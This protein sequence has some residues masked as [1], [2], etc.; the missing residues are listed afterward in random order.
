MN[1]FKLLHP[2][3]RAILEELGYKKPTSIQEKAIPILC[4]RDTNALIVAPTG[5]GKTEAAL[6]PVLSKY[7]ELKDKKHYEGIVILWITP[8]R[9]LNRDFFRR[10]LPILA[11]RLGLS[12]SVRHGDTPSHV[13]RMQA[14]K[15]P[16]LLVITPETLQAILWGTKLRKALRN[17]KWVIIDEVQ[18]ILD[19]KRGVQLTIGLE[20]LRILSP[21]YHIIA[22]SATLANPIDAMKFITGG[23]KGIIIKDERRK[24]FDILIDIAPLILEK[25]VFKVDFQKLASKLASYVRQEKGKVLIFTNTRDL[26]ELIGLLLKKKLGEESVGVHHSSLSKEVRERIERNFAMGKLKCVVATASLELGIDIGEVDLVVQIGSP[27]RV[28][29]AIQRIG[30]SGHW[31]ERVSRGIIIALTPDDLLESVSIVD[32]ITKGKL[33]QIKPLRKCYD[34]LIHQIVGITRDIYLDRG[35]WPS[36]WEVYSIVKNAEPY[37]EL[38][39]KEFQEV[40]KFAEERCRLIRIENDRIRLRK[41]AIQ[42]YFGQLSTIPTEVRF[43]VY[44]VIERKNIGEID[45]KYAFSIDVGHTFLLAGKAREV[46]EI[47]PSEKKVIV[48]PIA[49]S[50]VPPK[51]V[52]E[53]FPVSYLVASNIKYVEKEN[54]LKMTKEAE[55]LFDNLISN[56]IDGIAWDIDKDSGSIVLV[57]RFGN[58]VNRTI[59]AALGAVCR[60]IG[61]IPLISVDVDA[62]RIY[63]RLW[64][65]TPQYVSEVKI[66]LKMLEDIAN[67]YEKFKEIVKR[68]LVEFFQADLAWYLIHVLRRLGILSPTETIDYSYATKLLEMYYGTLVFEEVFNEY[69][70]KNLDLEIAQE[71]LLN[72]ISDKLMHVPQRVRELL[73]PI[74]ISDVIL[75]EQ[76]KIILD[77]R[78]VKLVC[79]SCGW[80]TDKTVREA[81]QVIKSFSCPKCGSM[82]ITITKKHDE[83]LPLIIQKSRKVK[84]TP[85]EKEKFLLAL[86][87]AHTAKAMPEIIYAIATHGVSLEHALSIVTSE[88]RTSF[89]S[90]LRKREAMFFKTRLFWM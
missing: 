37:S 68:G 11:H 59:A 55:E 48:T 80:S 7:L 83:E 8:L 82:R 67:N 53:L 14:E 58:N 79:L 86:K 17:V 3:L 51:W 76:F 77:E 75:D 29:T 30:R 22:L 73:P 74:I 78:K 72:H 57:T 69:A 46:I 10:F 87:V 31:I 64:N 28:E 45:E 60:A 88:A 40:L 65:A 27:R 44:D 6:F 23:R 71:I 19:D 41:G 70:H 9:A 5:S 49:E 2:K 21:N 12:I 20:R 33:E 43:K 35:E 36:I 38:T 26:A 54:N 56:V 85:R 89:F 39:M 24:E 50:T 47:R 62:H 34:V 42:Y 16:E 15:P 1:A 81:I 84:L 13:R 18:S 66:A 32:L 25:K 4:E 52:G 90:E 63:L 61:K